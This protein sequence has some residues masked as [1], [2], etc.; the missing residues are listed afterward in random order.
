METCG[1][2]N[3]HLH[4]TRS[5]TSTTSGT[6]SL[7]EGTTL[8]VLK[9]S[10]WPKLAILTDHPQEDKEVLLIATTQVTE[11]VTCREHYSS[12]NQ[13]VRTSAWMLRFILHCQSKTPAAAP[14]LTTQ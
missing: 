7:V 9:C 8:V 12:Y 5:I 11:L 3:E 4:I 14:Y 2:A 1:V 10:E 13:V 6:P